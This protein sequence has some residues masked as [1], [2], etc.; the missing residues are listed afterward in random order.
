MLKAGEFLL[1]P[2]FYLATNRR[3]NALNPIND[4]VSNNDY[5]LKKNK[6][7]K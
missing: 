6:Y 2:S 1:K 5:G 3:K 7:C 4:G